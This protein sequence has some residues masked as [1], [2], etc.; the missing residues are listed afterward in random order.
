MPDRVLEVILGADGLFT[1]F[2]RGLPVHQLMR[3]AMAGNLVTGVR[4][5]THERGDPF[6]E[7]AEHEER[8][9]HLVCI[10]DP[11]KSLDVADDTKFARRPA[12]AS[13]R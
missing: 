10:Q 3:E 7:P 4:N 12:V 1:K 13:D 11:E 9:V 8:R 2:N 5:S 6:G